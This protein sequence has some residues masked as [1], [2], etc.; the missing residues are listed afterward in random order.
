MGLHK[1][2]LIDN[3]IY[4]QCLKGV[5]DEV[6]VVWGYECIHS[7]W[8]A[9]FAV[10]RLKYPKVETKWDLASIVYVEAGELDKFAMVSWALWQCRNKLWCKET[11]TPI[12]KIYKAALSLLVEFQ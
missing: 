3:P 8:E 4:D 1:R 2:K 10:V 7:A 5:E 9:P 11:S 12:H 6:H